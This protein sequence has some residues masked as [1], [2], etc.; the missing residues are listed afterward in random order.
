MKNIFPVTYIYTKCNDILKFS[1]NNILIIVH[2]DFSNTALF[3]DS[4]TM[5]W[6][7]VNK[8]C[9][10]P[11]P[12]NKVMCLIEYISLPAMDALDRFTIVNEDRG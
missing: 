8:I 2:I 7:F 4:S 11:L 3:I 6:R 10:S 12:H 1:I 9:M 5:Y